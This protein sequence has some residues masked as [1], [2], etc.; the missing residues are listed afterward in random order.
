ME[1]KMKQIEEYI[2][3]LEKVETTEVFDAIV[4]TGASQDFS[5]TSGLAGDFVSSSCL[6]NQP[7]GCGNGKNCSNCALICW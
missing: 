4:L 6:N 1:K 7:T 2:N 5:L 3:S